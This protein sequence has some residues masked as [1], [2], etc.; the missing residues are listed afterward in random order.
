VLTVKVSKQQT[1]NFKIAF[2][3]VHRKK[4]D[5]SDIPATSSR[6]KRLKV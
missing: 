3:K 4:S 5:L 6:W 2:N 1:I